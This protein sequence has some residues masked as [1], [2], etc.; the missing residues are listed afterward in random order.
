MRFLRLPEICILCHGESYIMV[1][2]C[3][4]KCYQY[5]KGAEEKERWR[6]KFGERYRV[7]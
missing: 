3:C 6:E 4:I 1:T 7:R 2:N 5:M